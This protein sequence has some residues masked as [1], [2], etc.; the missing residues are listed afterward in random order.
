MMI[1]LLGGHLPVGFSSPQSVGPHHRAGRMRMIGVGGTRPVASFPDVP[2]IAQSG[3]PGYEANIWYG[4][5]APGGT[6]REVATKIQQ[7]IAKVLAEPEVKERL[8][9]LGTEP[10][11]NTPEEFDAIVRAELK[12][13]AKVVQDA[14][15]KVE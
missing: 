13:W 9:S 8:A 4:L 1:E 10:V 7:Q 6:P 15:I 11:G 12:K 3:L 2:V 14:G 5:L